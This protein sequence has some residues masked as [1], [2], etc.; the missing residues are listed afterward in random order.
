MPMGRPARRALGKDMAGAAIVLDM[1]DRHAFDAGTIEQVRN[2]ANDLLAAMQR[3]RQ[4]EHA[5]LHVDDHQGGR[6]RPAYSM[7]TKIE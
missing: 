4:G 7:G 6:H 5:L 1:D 3:R 2:A